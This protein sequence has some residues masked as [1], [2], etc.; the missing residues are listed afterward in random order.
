VEALELLEQADRSL[1]LAKKAGRR[2]V[3]VAARPHT[4]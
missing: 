3:V 1:G 2:R 4:H